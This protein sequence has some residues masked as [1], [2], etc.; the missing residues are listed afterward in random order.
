MKTYKA[1]IVLV[2]CILIAHTMAYNDEVEQ[3][4]RSC[5]NAV[6]AFDNPLECGNKHE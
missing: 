2:S 4:A 6:Y 1:V 3:S 5:T